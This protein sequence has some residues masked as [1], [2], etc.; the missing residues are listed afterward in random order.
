MRTRIPL[1]TFAVGLLSLLLTV[2]AAGSGLPQAAN[3][4]STGSANLPPV[5]EASTLPRRVV[6]LGS[7]PGSA[8]QVAIP[9]TTMAISGPRRWLTR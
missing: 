4:Q 3:P 6:Y 9:A 8:V 7:A 1:T 5:I 2:A